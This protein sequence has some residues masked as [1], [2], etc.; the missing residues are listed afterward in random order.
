FGPS[1]G[2]RIPVDYADAKH[3]EKCIKSWFWLITRQNDGRGRRRYRLARYAGS[4]GNSN[5]NVVWLPTSDR[6][7]IDPPNAFMTS[8]QNDRPTPVPPCPCLVEKNS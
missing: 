8:R 1:T 2:N 3:R 5:T 7:D 4:G 6:H